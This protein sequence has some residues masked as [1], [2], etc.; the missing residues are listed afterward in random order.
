MESLNVFNFRRKSKYDEDI[1]K[2]PTEVTA[3]SDNECKSQHVDPSSNESAHEE[4]LETSLVSQSEEGGKNQ[5]Q[6]SN[7]DDH[8]H[9]HR[10]QDKGLEKSFHTPASST[11]RTPQDHSSARSRE[12]NMGD[13][14]EDDSFI[15]G[16]YEDLGSIM[17]KT[18]TPRASKLQLQLS[19]EL[20]Y[21]SY[22]TDEGKAS[23]SANNREPSPSPANKRPLLPHRRAT[24][25]PNL[26]LAISS[27]TTSEASTDYDHSM[28]MEELY[29]NESEASGT[30]VITH[31]PYH[32]PKTVSK[33][34]P[35]LGF[36]NQVNPLSR[37]KSMSS[38]PTHSKRHS[39]AAYQPTRPAIDPIAASEAS[40]SSSALSPRSA[41]LL[42][43]HMNIPVKDRYSFAQREQERIER[44]RLL[45]VKSKITPPHR[46]ISGIWQEALTDLH[47]TQ[48]EKVQKTKGK[49][50]LQAGLV[51]RAISR[52]E[53]L[54]MSR[55]AS[56]D[57]IR[58]TLIAAK[59]K[60]NTPKRLSAADL[61]RFSQSEGSSFYH[62]ATTQEMTTLSE[63]TT[64][65]LTEK[66]VVG[67]T[68]IYHLG[69]R[70]IDGSKDSHEMK[71]RLESVMNQVK[72]SGE[73]VSLPAGV[74]ILSETEKSLSSLISV[75]AVVFRAE[76]GDVYLALTVDAP[77]NMPIASVD[78]CLTKVVIFE[79]QRESGV[80]AGSAFSENM[81]PPKNNI[82][83]DTFLLQAAKQPKS[84]ARAYQQSSSSSSSKLLLQQHGFST[85]FR[86]SETMDTPSQSMSIIMEEDES[87]I[88]PSSISSSHSD[89]Y[90]ET[91]K[92]FH[93][94]I[95]SGVIVH[96]TILEEDLNAEIDE[97]AE[98]QDE[99]D[100]E[101]GEEEVEGIWMEVPSAP[102]SA[103]SSPRAKSTPI[104]P[105]ALLSPT[106]API[107]KF[108]FGESEAAAAVSATTNATGASATSTTAA[109]ASSSSS[110]SQ[111]IWSKPILTPSSMEQLSPTRP[112]VQHQRDGE[113]DVAS[114][115]DDEHDDY[116]TDVYDSCSYNCS[117]PMLMVQWEDIRYERFQALNTHIAPILIESIIPINFED[118][119]SIACSANHTF[120]QLKSDR[121]LKINTRC[122]CSYHP[123][124]SSSEAQPS[125]Q[126]IVS[127]GNGQRK[128]FI[129]W[130]RGVAAS[131][132]MMKWPLSSQSFGMPSKRFFML[133]GSRL[134]YYPIVPSF[135]TS[136]SAQRPG[137]LSDMRSNVPPMEI[138]RITDQSSIG[139]SRK[140]L[141]RCLRMVGLNERFSHQGEDILW[142]RRLPQ[143]AARAVAMA[144]KGTRAPGEKYWHQ[145]IHR[146]IQHNQLTS[147]LPSCSL[148][149]S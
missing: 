5:S 146:S 39:I 142:F 123:S 16:S 139:Y 101:E 124:A 20:E 112:I 2:I 68:S 117:L 96:G 61:K 15:E 14:Y 56:N 145:A 126:I 105:D 120:L 67:S 35:R 122:E 91:W 28:S 140:R 34:S 80:G 31:N 141:Q 79:E 75:V 6:S 12:I 44:E 133:R 42:S 102:T 118:I 45:K 86:A 22:G 21:P 132:W 100:A 10:P 23:N 138:L 72:A 128:L 43:P 148:A 109:S 119:R 58:R 13:I 103:P 38:T 47:T 114:L 54:M 78:G 37:A 24:F 8:H 77:P 135:R 26:H 92:S 69:D 147:K 7:I 144:G 27:P 136:A 18:K 108:F 64:E 19:D 89:L 83:E 59:K 129:E 110:S 29:S 30:E 17:P 11:N 98:E 62:T 57:Q 48:S 9:L 97:H 55:T 95:N 65:N 84:P 106:T 4:Y 82:F 93:S 111:D 1:R 52:W 107:Y 99:A 74:M 32:T 71:L 70:L 50:V 33:L 137:L 49:V 85:S 90:K 116:A 66:F 46:Q 53:E 76:D 121:L 36:G 88:P 25:H 60:L 73:A 127:T 131:G 143:A 87:M 81:T 40:S 41:M 149:L 51:K 63:E 130:T 104:T 115:S 113:M 3:N 134:T 94:P 125:Q